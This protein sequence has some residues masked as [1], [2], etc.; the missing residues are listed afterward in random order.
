MSVCVCVCV[1][2]CVVCVCIQIYIV[3][4]GQSIVTCMIKWTEN[5]P[6]TKNKH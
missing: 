5:K 2:V 4:C 6:K 1:C 3:I